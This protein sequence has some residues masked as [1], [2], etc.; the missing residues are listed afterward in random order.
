MTPD[1]EDWP[2]PP[3]QA[4]EE[5]HS[6]ERVEDNPE[7]APLDT[8]T[9]PTPAELQ[10]FGKKSAS[11]QQNDNPELVPLLGGIPLEVIENQEQDEQLEAPEDVTI[12]RLVS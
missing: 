3:E 4:V 9:W 5:H 8:E 2:M 12:Q 10:A 11:E 6:F 7:F 1:Y